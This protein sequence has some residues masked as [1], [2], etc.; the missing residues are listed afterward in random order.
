MT[1]LPADILGLTDRGRIAEGQVA[2]IA[3]FDAARIRETNSFEHPK[4]YAEGVRH[5]LVN[6]VAVIDDGE[7][8]GARPGRVLRGRAF[9]QPPAT[10]AITGGSN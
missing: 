10:P 5:V 2:D 9:G 6:G 4:S 1:S 7:H 3:V 8:T